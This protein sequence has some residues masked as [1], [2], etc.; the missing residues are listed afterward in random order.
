MC[1]AWLIGEN[2]S[3]AFYSSAFPLVLKQEKIFSLENNLISKQYP[4]IHFLQCSTVGN[5]YGLQIVNGQMATRNLLCWGKTS[6]RGVDLP[7]EADCFFNKMRHRNDILMKQDARW[8]ISFLHVL[9]TFWG[10]KKLGLAYSFYDDLNPKAHEDIAE[11][12]S[13]QSDDTS[14][15]SLN[16]LTERNLYS[17]EPY[18]VLW[19]HLLSE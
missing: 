16:D 18:T 9:S 11:D 5:L 15:V 19:I 6:K 17:M 4:D 13:F 1:K 10:D 7:L 8:W 3:G 14:S 12:F 2:T